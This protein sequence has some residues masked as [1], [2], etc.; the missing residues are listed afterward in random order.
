M[1]VGQ[2]RS[3]GYAYNS[4]RGGARRKLNMG[5]RKRMTPTAMMKQVVLRTAEKKMKFITG[6]A[7]V[8][9]VGTTATAADRPFVTNALTTDVGTS[10]FTRIGDKIYSQRLEVKGVLQNEALNPG[11]NYRIIVVRGEA[12]DMPNGDTTGFFYAG[13]YTG[14]GPILGLVNGDKFTVVKDITFTASDGD[15]SVETAT[16]V[17]R[18][19]TRMFSFTIP[20][21]KYIEYKD[22]AGTIPKGANCYNMF[23]YGFDPNGGAGS[24]GIVNFSVRHYFKD[25]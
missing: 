1:V 22:D 17:N 10:Q 9:N 16:A 12:A 11:A 14:A 13:S 6:S 5:K 18:S 4:G 3:R 20:T 7:F 23:C 24:I 15:Y 25:V 2:K 8:F 19:K 21:N